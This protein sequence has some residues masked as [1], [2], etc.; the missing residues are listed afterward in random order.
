[1][2]TATV[3]NWHAD[4]VTAPAQDYYAITPSDSTNFGT[5]FRGIYVGTGGNVVAVSAGGAAITFIGALAGTVLP[6]AGVRV[7]NTN[8]TASNLVGLV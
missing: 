3:M 7:N 1:M 2:A 8:T 4:W 6:V 5:P